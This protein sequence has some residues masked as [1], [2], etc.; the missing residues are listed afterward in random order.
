[1]EPFCVGLTEYELIWS[2]LDPF[3]AQLHDLGKMNFHV[4]VYF[5]CL[6]APWARLGPAG[7]ASRGQDWLWAGRWERQNMSLNNPP[8]TFRTF[9]T[10]YRIG[11]IYRSHGNGA[12]N[13]ASEPTFHTRRV[14]G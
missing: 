7:W 3:Q 4:F 11:G 9:G 5:L 10:R 13:C 8:I 2:R 1:M 14:P 12:M 6:W